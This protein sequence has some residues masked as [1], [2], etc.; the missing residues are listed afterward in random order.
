MAPNS[1]ATLAQA[2]PTLACR[3]TGR[4]P[5]FLL[6]IAHLH[7]VY[8]GE[9][10]RYRIPWRARLVEPAARFLP[11]SQGFFVQWA[12]QDSNL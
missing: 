11:C 12:A 10:P 1:G 9:V 2:R 8:R 7:S 3:I 6:R 4:V 5:D